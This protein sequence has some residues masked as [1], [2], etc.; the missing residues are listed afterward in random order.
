MRVFLLTSH[1]R[2][3]HDVMILYRIIE[4]NNACQYHKEGMNEL[5]IRNM[6]LFLRMPTSRQLCS[7][8]PSRVTFV[9]SRIVIGILPITEYYKCFVIINFFKNFNPY[10]FENFK[11]TLPK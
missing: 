6:G 5:K 3:A 1:L 11:K 10:F 8:G 4:K 9:P 7:L 2:K